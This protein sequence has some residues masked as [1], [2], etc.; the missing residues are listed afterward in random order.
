MK[1]TNHI[2]D[3]LLHDLKQL[4]DKCTEMHLPHPPISFISFQVHDADGSLI[5]TYDSKSNSW[6]RNAHNML[7]GLFLPA[8]SGAGTSTYGAGSLSVKHTGGTTY[9]DSA[10][11]YPTSPEGATI[12]AYVCEAAATG[13]FGIWVGSGTGAES[14][15]D[16]TVTKIA[17]GSA[18]G[19]L[20]YGIMALP[21]VTYDSPTKTWTSVITRVFNNNSAA[22]IAVNE[23]GLVE[24]LAYTT[25]NAYFLVARDL[26]S[27]TITVPVGGQLSVS[28]TTTYTMPY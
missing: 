10:L 4:N 15:E 13:S 7:A 3:E 18:A 11:T 20:L 24:Y 2:T 25:A 19:Q 27:G 6:V 9:R 1:T 17:A 22:S 8:S 23:V 5:E 21:T 16:Y 26:L 14:F 28:Y 12:A